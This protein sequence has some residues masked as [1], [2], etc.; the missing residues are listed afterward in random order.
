MSVSVAAI[1]KQRTDRGGMTYTQSAVL[2][3]EGGL[4]VSSV[5]KPTNAQGSSEFFVINTFQILPRHV[6]AYGCHPQGVVSTL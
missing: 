5:I 2:S 6:S 4:F 1:L 3:T